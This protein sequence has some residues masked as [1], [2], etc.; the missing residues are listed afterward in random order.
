MHFF[1]LL[2]STNEEHILGFRIWHSKS[3]K[4]L[5]G[6][7]KDWHDLYRFVVQLGLQLLWIR[8]LSHCFHEVLLS[9]VLTVRT[10]G[11]Q[12]CRHVDK[13]LVHRNSLTERG[14]RWLSLMSNLLL[15]K[16]FW[17]QLRWNRPTAWQWL[18]NLKI[19]AQCQVQIPICVQRQLHIYRR[20]CNQHV[21][22]NEAAPHTDLSLR[23][24]WWDWSGS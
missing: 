2:P 7:E 18:Q 11:E 15:C 6:R 21:M 5:S 20:R 17:D 4:N 22:V 3:M 1:L 13:G 9:D 14:P 12:T 16:H 24:W 8:H 23:A 19:E 10:D